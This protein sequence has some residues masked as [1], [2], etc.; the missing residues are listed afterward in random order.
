MTRQ[1][2]VE[3]VEGG[4]GRRALPS[5]VQETYALRELL[6]RR[7]DATGTVAYT[8]PGKWARTRPRLRAGLRHGRPRI[9]R[10]P[11]RPPAVEIP[12][13]ALASRRAPTP[14]PRPRPDDPALPAA[15]RGDPR[16]HS[17]IGSPFLAHQTDG[18]CP[19]LARFSRG[20]S[21]DYDQAV[22]KVIGECLE[23]APLLYFRMADFVRGSARSLR[24]SGRRILEP[25]EIRVFSGEQ[26]EARPELRFDDDS[27]FH[28]TRLTSLL[29]SEVA[30]MPAQL[31]YWN[32]P[33]A[34]GDVPEPMLREGST[35]G[36]G[37]FFSVE[38]AILSGALECIQRDGFFLHW[39]RGVAP[40]RIDVATLR[41]PATLKLI[42]HARSVGLEP[43][44]F[45]I[46]TELGV[47]VCLCILLPPELHITMGGVVPPRR[48]VRRSRRAP[49]GG[50]RSPR[51]GPRQDP[52]PRP[53]R[54]RR[55]D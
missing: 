55:A 12:H 5:P 54:L 14:S 29:T 43:L 39:L 28:W 24:A 38:G 44:F 49:R 48:R 47:P 36:A 16:P 42:E 18:A 6:P 46:T 8:L 41:R 11:V 9:R 53:R 37:G 32:Y 21:E 35:H 13:A 3:R 10:P 31:V 50:E 34:W 40:P 45:D 1:I 2:V 33:T 22:S 4:A 7:P 17:D 20:F 27:V 26:R 15:R 30:L 25:S 52:R 51:H 19:D 23:R